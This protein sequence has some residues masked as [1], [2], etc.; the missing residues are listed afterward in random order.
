M[1]VYG[2]ATMIRY[3]CPKCDCKLIV[4]EDLA[5]TLGKCAKCHCYHTF[6]TE[7]SRKHNEATEKARQVLALS[8]VRTACEHCNEMVFVK[9][10]HVGLEVFCSACRNT[11]EIKDDPS[12]LDLADLDMNE[13]P[14]GEFSDPSANEGSVAELTAK[15]EEMRQEL[16]EALQA[17]EDAEAKAA[18]AE[19]RV[20]NEKKLRAAI[21]KAHEATEERLQSELNEA[22]RQMAES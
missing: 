19:S 4:F 18:D 21:E 13:P 2:W 12:G 1:P 10:R 7:S 15:L 11:F 20:Q 22:R 14:R 5:R 6:P 3:H 8:T 16:E 17:K 9:P